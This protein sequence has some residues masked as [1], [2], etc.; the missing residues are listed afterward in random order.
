MGWNIIIDINI[1]LKVK[2]NAF[3]VLKKTNFITNRLMEIK[4]KLIN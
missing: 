1:T 3:L 2:I 4:K